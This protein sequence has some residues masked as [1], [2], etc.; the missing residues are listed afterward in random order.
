MILEA[1]EPLDAWKVM[2]HVQTVQFD[3]MKAI[4][5]Y[6]EAADKAEWKTALD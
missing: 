6:Q 1:V 5:Y 3:V 2:A 4:E